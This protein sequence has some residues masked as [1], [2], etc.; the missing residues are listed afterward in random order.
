[1][2]SRSYN[3]YMKRIVRL[4]L[5]VVAIAAMTG[6]AYAG[7]SAVSKG[8]SVSCG[9]F[10]CGFQSASSSHRTCAWTATWN[11]PYDKTDKTAS[12]TVTLK[13]RGFKRLRVV[14]SGSKGLKMKSV[15]LACTGD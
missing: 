8:V 15:S 5:V 10:F 2:R 6:A 13:P 14:K 9:G 12:G 1:M 7:A 11:E 4:G 3:L